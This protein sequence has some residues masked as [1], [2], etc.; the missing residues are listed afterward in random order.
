MI[1]RADAAIYIDFN[2][3]EISDYTAG[4]ELRFSL[5]RIDVPPGASHAGAY[6]QRS[7]KDYFVPEGSI[8]F[9]LDGQERQLGMCD[10]CV[11][12]Q[13]IRISYWNRAEQLSILL[14]HHTSIFDP[15]AEIFTET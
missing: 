3:L 13:G 5:A 14:L 11:V 8:A 2:G 1:V 7:D 12:S 9:R 15:Q 10:F 4:Q 6:S